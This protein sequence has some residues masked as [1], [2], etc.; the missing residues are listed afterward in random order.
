MVQVG[1]GEQSS[2]FFITP[3]GDEAKEVRFDVIV[4]SLKSAG[5]FLKPGVDDWRWIVLANEEQVQI[6]GSSK[7]RNQG[8]STSPPTSR[9]V[10]VGGSLL[11]YTPKCV[12][13]TFSEVR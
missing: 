3:P 5:S 13:Q 8:S 6:K 7:A 2:N 1:G 4:P 12:E 9:A 11:P 10:G